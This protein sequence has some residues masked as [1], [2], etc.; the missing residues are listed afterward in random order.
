ML[1]LHSFDCCFVNLFQ[2]VFIS[3]LFWTTST[4]MLCAVIIKAMVRILILYGTSFL[5]S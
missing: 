5:R 4:I 3:H 1:G 2:D